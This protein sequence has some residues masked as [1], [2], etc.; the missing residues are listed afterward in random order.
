MTGLSDV[1]AGIGTVVLPVHLAAL[2][3]ALLRASGAGDIFRWGDVT[4]IPKITGATWTPARQCSERP[5]C[6]APSPITV[7]G[8]GCAGILHRGN[9]RRTMGLLTARL[10]K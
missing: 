2:F 1:M 10:T 3:D 5:P 4:D 8:G 9:A 6:P 7:K